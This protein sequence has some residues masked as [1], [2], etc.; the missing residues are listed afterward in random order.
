MNAVASLRHFIAALAFA[1]LQPLNL[2]AESSDTLHASNGT[3]PGSMLTLPTK[4]RTR[5][6][7]RTVPRV[8]HQQTAPK[9]GAPSPALVLVVP[10]A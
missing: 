4:V 7:A 8:R 2:D 10:R 9:C 1:N 5:T 6:R 3:S